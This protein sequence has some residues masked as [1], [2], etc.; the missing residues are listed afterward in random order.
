M[1]TL[2][3]ARGL[4]VHLGLAAWIAVVAGITLPAI[5][6]QAQAQAVRIVAFGAS[7][8]YG[9][10]AGG[11]PRAFPARLQALL[12]AKGHNVTITNAGISGNTTADMLR[13]LNSAVPQGT[14]IVI[15]GAC[16]GLFNNQRQGVSSGDS[17]IAAIKGRLQGRGI[18]VIEACGRGLPRGSDNI[19]LSPAGHAMLANQLLPEVLGALGKQ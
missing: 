19:H 15:F 16:E 3:I 18:R 12:K 1:G 8:T 17:D 6:A 9:Q 14:R 5:W 2:L 4:R 10:N 11:P 7:N 13:R